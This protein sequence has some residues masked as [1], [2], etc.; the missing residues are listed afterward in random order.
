MRSS[1]SD[2]VRSTARLAALARAAHGS[3]SSRVASLARREEASPEGNLGASSALRMERPIL[4]ATMTPALGAGLERWL[5]G[6]QHGWRVVGVVSD[7][8]GL[9]R[10]ISSDLAV[11]VAS[12]CL[13]GVLVGA[14]LREMRSTCSLLALA[15]DPDAIA[16]ADLLRAGASCVLPVRTAQDQLVRAV[17]D[18]MAGRPSTSVEALRLLSAGVGA[19]A[20]LT[21]RQQAVLALLARGLTSQQIARDLYIAPSTV[22]THVARLA[23]RFGLSGRAE[24]VRRAPSL[25]AGDAAGGPRASS[26]GGVPDDT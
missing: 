14:D 20:A 18:L 15:D 24:L 16:E 5:D 2:D 4:I 11:V 7:R 19:E 25:L 13:D 17:A 1:L 23:A 9:R 3:S 21:G 22:K 6:A 8:A 26:G 12:V 10:S